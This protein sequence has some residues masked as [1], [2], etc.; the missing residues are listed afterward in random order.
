MK[1]IQTLKFYWLKYEISAIQA[2][3]Y[4][5]PGIDNF[6][7]SFYLSNTT[8]EN[9]GMQ[10]VSYAFMTPANQYSTN[11]DILTPYK[12]NALELS[13]PFIMS[14]NIISAADMLLLINT[15]DAVGDKP[16]YLTFIPNISDGQHIYYDIKR[17]K[18]ID[19]G[20]VEIKSQGASPV[21]TNPSP[22]ATVIK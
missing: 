5:S 18:R 1:D 15:P 16:D 12:N 9:K 10:L 22:P 2:L 8:D 11:Y 21:N 7:F 19:V 3:I 13:G 20:D 17:Y 4:N 6:V 14:N